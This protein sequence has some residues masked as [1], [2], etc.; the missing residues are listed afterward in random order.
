MGCWG[1]RFIT[2]YGLKLKSLP[3]LAAST[4]CG[5]LIP[6]LPVSTAPTCAAAIC[7]ALTD[8]DLVDRA[9]ELN[10][11]T[12]RERLDQAV[13]RPQVITMYEKIAAQAAMKERVK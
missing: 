6:L 4:I 12:A 5:L 3:H 11:R 1:T 2:Y 13:I 8:D 9:A 10:A 7:R